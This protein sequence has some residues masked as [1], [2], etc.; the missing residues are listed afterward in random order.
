MEREKAGFVS[1][2][3]TMNGIK[4]IKPKNSLNVTPY[5]VAR[6][7]R[8]KKEPE[9]PNINSLMGWYYNT[10]LKDKTNYLKYAKK[11]FELDWA[12]ESNVSNYLYA[13]Y[14]NKQFKTAKEILDDPKYLRGN[15]IMNARMIFDYYAWQGDYDNA[16]ILL[17]NIKPLN[18]FRYYLE[19]AWINSM[20]GNA[21]IVYDAFKS[22]EQTNVT[23]ANCFA[24]LKQRDSM[25][26]YLDKISSRKNPEYRYL[27]AMKINSYVAYHPYLN[28][29]KFRAFLKKHY[30]PIITTS[31]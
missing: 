25:Y 15:D 17:E 10:I 29:P 21:E 9:N 6:T 11:A 8:F 26:F 7:E 24:H 22:W 20:M 28:G 30:L 19:K 2:F 5:A 16:S 3:G 1:Q 18:P 13:L 31:E 27:D 4:N 23:K 12:S 14:L